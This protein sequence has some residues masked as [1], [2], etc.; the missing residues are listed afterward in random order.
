MLLEVEETLAVPHVPQRPAENRVGQVNIV[1]PE[2]PEL[3]QRDQALGDTVDV[4]GVGGVVIVFWSSVFP[5]KVSR[6]EGQTTA[7]GFVKIRRLTI[8]SDTLQ[9]DEVIPGVEVVDPLLGR[10]LAIIP[11]TVLVLF[12]DRVAGGV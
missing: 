10:R 1:F 4:D 5:E 7:D 6:V 2:I 8:I 9:S 11:R 3:G 12:A